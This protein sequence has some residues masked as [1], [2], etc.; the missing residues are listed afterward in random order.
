M[1][2]HTPS[3]FWGKN[4]DDCTSYCAVVFLYSSLGCVGMLFGKFL[5]NNFIILMWALSATGLLALA[6][7]KMGW[8]DN[9]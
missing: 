1:G 7:Y 9:L 8:L 2:L 6:A 4:N 3:F 5:I